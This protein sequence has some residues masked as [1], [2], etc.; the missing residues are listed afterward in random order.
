MAR[1]A[2]SVREVGAAGAASGRKVGAL[3]RGMMILTKSLK[4]GSLAVLGIGA[5]ATKMGVQFDS[6]LLR[7]QTQ[8]GESA[9]RMGYLRKSILDMTQSGKFEQG[10]QALVDALYRLEGAGLRGA[11]AMKALRAAADLAAVG[12]ANV[13][14]TAKTMAQTMFVGM[15]GTGNVNQLVAELN[16][17][18]GAGDLKLQQLVDALGTGVTASAKQAGLSFHDVTGAL[19]VFGDETNNVSGWAAQ[20]ATALHFLY[21]PTTKAAGAMKTMGLAKDDLAKDMAGPNGLVTALSDLRSHIDALPGGAHGVKARQLLSDILPGGRGRV[22]LVLLNQLDRLQGKMGQIHDTNKVFKKSVHDNQ[23]QP[24]FKLRA[25]WSGVEGAMI[26]FYDVIKPLVIPV[27]IVLLHVL[28]NVVVFLTGTEKHVKAVV[29]W[30]NNLPEPV[31]LAAMALGIFVAQGLALY[32]VIRIFGMVR[33]GLLA[34]RYGIMIVRGA[35]ILLTLGSGPLM[36]ALMALVTIAVLIVTHW[37]WVKKALGATWD[38]IKQAAV[39]AFGAIV[40]AARHGL[41][42]LPGLIITHFNEIVNFIRGVPGRL[43]KAGSGMWNWI[44]TAFKNALNWV[45]GAWDKLHFSI[46]GW[47]IFGH[48]LP[49]VTVGLG[50]IPFLAGGGNI[51]PG[52]LAVVGDRGPELASVDAS[53]ARITPLSRTGSQPSLAGAFR[54]HFEIPVMVGGREIARATADQTSDWNARRGR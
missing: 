44:K 32:A 3:G 19:A 11:A 25:A 46:G 45:I 10:P 35:M 53:G 41:L 48:S 43:A 7:I 31:K 28:R 13:E 20:F 42:G 26:R 34:I 47:K 22:L 37:S 18:V 21:A 33:A 12:N 39:N 38:W 27:L 50:Q 51:P 36:L 30:W 54:F 14:D 52:G 23:Q 2:A 8:A 40:W 24:L 1:S 49:K 6:A 15:K 29:H 17:T 16:A 9:S 5:E 4:V